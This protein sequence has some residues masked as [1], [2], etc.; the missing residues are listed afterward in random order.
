MGVHASPRSDDGAGIDT[1][2]GD[3]EL[4]ALLAGCDA[5]VVV[6]GHTH[7]V[8]DRTIARIR[9]VN[10]G[11][12]SNPSRADRCAT[13]AIVHIDADI[14]RIEQRVVDYDHAAVLRAIDD[15]AH[16]AG[17]YLRSFHTPQTT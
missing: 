17:Q 1:R 15:V 10:L 9:A 6:A 11:S 4:A 13:Y 8:T 5:D 2:I 12:V 3:D 14:H 16:P 7:D